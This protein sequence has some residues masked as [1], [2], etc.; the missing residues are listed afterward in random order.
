MI[1]WTMALSVLAL[2]MGMATLTWVISVIKKDVRIGDSFW[3]IFIFAALLLGWY[4][5]DTGRGPRALP[6]LIP[7]LPEDSSKL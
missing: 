7:T 4:A 2:L 1:D 6:A 3:S 5:A